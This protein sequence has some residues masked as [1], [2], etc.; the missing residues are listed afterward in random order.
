MRLG[1]FLLAFAVGCVDAPSSFPP[2][3]PNYQE[4]FSLNT[5]D[6]FLAVGD[7][8]SLHVTNTASGKP[9][10]GRSVWSSS[11]PAVATVDEQG[12]VTAISNGTATIQALNGG[13]QRDDGSVVVTVVTRLTVSI[14]WAAPDER[15][16]AGF[17]DVT[18]SF[19]PLVLL[20]E[21]AEEGIYRGDEVLGW[22]PDH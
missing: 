1:Y 5:P 6:F 15:G 8:R 12:T 16:Y 20:Y 22:Q 2:F 21:N 3:A 17:V 14:Q 18:S 9:Y 19:W 11:N 10:A 4:V 7:S 13:G